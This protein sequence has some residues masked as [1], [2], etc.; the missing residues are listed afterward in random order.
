MLPKDRR[1]VLYHVENAHGF[2]QTRDRGASQNAPRPP[3]AAG[4][5]LAYI[6][7]PSE[8]LNSED[9]VFFI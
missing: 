4:Q 9:Q 2:M 6:G 5:L 8:V 7:L 3:R 1:S